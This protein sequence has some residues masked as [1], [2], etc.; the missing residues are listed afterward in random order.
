MWETTYY[1]R[2]VVGADKCAKQADSYKP[3]VSGNSVS[4][5]VEFAVLSYDIQRCPNMSRRSETLSKHRGLVAM[6]TPPTVGCSGSPA[7]LLLL[8]PRRLSRNP[9]AC[10]PKALPGGAV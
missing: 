5:V 3:S 7:L 2:F 8:K 6:F 10:V 9:A 4:S 1:C